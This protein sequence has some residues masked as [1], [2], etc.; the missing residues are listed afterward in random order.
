MVAFNDMSAIGAI[1]ALQDFGMRV[2]EDVS[3]IGFDDIKA[4]E[5]NNPRLTTIR[6]PLANMG[7]IAAQC[8]LNRIHEREKF[9]KQI[10]VLEPELVV[11]ESNAGHPS[12]ETGGSRAQE[13]SIKNDL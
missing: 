11:R 13:R 4:A 2:P 8:V 12:C 5:F 3:V 1:R 9:R 6:Q 10:I 7:R